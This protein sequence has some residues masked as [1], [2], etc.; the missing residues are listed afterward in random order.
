[1]YVHHPLPLKNVKR[2][3]CDWTS[4]PRLITVLHIH[5]IIY[6]THIYF[7]FFF[8]WIC[9]RPMA[10][11]P[12]FLSLTVFLEHGCR[13]YGLLSLPSPQ[14]ASSTYTIYN[15]RVRKVL[16]FIFFV[17]F[18]QRHFD[19]E[20]MNDSTRRRRK[21]SMFWRLVVMG[22]VLRIKCLDC[23]NGDQRQRR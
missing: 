13:G 7:L 9:F 15:L 20:Q 22:N 17:Y 1:M 3:P 18:L 2:R 10:N 6:E 12:L 19:R 5:Y 8:L 4:K 14:N 21:I 11:E 23:A 16:F